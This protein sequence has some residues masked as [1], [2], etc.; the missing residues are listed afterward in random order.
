MGEFVKLWENRQVM[1]R[2][3]GFSERILEVSKIDNKMNR[4]NLSLALLK[5]AKFMLFQ[6]LST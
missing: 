6:F 2:S 1:G 3:F 5:S 4:L